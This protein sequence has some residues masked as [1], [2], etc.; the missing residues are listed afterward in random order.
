MNSRPPSEH[1]LLFPDPAPVELARA[2][3]LSGYGWT[4]AHSHS[5]LGSTEEWTGAIVSLGDDDERGWLLCRDLRRRDVPIEPLLVL[6]PGDRLDELDERAE[7]FDD[8]L[9]TPF[10]P[11]ELEAR[12]KHL[13]W[14]VGR[15]VRPE[16]VEHGP[17]RL[18]TETYQAQIDGRPLDLTYMEYEL[19]RF[20][21]STPG[22][23][24][25]R[26]TLLNQVWGYEYYGGARTVDVHIRRLRAK[27]GQEHGHLIQTIRSVG[28]K[29]GQ[30]RWG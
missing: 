16:L 6:V 27:L 8:F 11:A 19:L 25:S 24:F 28:Y 10:H 2:L 5:G 7:L 9:I 13:L 4:A 14:R 18:N 26:E 3:S 30:S 29:L 12:I 20:L 21:A 1:F 15:G 23:V 22:R 17:L